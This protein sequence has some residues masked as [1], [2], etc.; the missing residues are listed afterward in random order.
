MHGSPSQYAPHKPLS[1]SEEYDRITFK[2]YI[3]R[4]LKFPFSSW[5]RLR[6]GS[7]AQ[8]YNAYP[9]TFSELFYVACFVKG[10]GIQ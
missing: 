8:S 9:N 7:E 5:V 3:R 1:G 10:K 2:Y 6:T 4:S